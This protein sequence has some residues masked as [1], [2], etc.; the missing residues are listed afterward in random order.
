MPAVSTVNLAP[1]RIPLTF[2]SRSR[3]SAGSKGKEKEGE[4]EGEVWVELLPFPAPSSSTSSSGGE[5]GDVLLDSRSKDGR[6]WLLSPSAN[7]IALFHPPPSAGA[8]LVFSHAKLFPASLPPVRAESEDAEAATLR[9]AAKRA[10]RAVEKVLVVVRSRTALAHVL[11]PHPAPSLSSTLSSRARCTI[12]SDLPS[13][14]ASYSLSATLPSGVHVGVYVSPLRDLFTLSL[15][16]PSAPA[17]TSSV[18]AAADT[19]RWSTRLSSLGSPPSFASAP[20]LEAFLLSALPPSSSGTAMKHLL[21]HA[22][23]PPFS[24]LIARVREAHLAALAPPPLSLSPLRQTEQEQEREGAAEKRLISILCRA[25]SLPRP[26]PPSPVAQR[27]PSSRRRQD[28]EG[29]GEEEEGDEEGQEEGGARRCLPGLGWIIR[30]PQTQTLEGGGGAAGKGG[31]EGRGWEYEVLFLDGEHL[32][33][34]L[35]CEPGFRSPP[36]DM[37]ARKSFEGGRVEV[38][39]RHGVTHVLPP[40]SPTEGPPPLLPKK[41]QRRMNLVVEMLALFLPSAPS[42]VDKEEGEGLM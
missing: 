35:F 27:L 18:P 33:L 41:L 15:S 9:K 25:L 21:T 8:P 34:R 3:S 7:S 32:R 5:G 36:S 40:P 26:V 28:G 12:F 10:W 4:A 42:S 31:K 19:K 38:E 6:V 22:L 39:D 29:A 30:S 37:E 23:S 13:S 20:D 16:P 24:A 11:L 2:S 1:F 17:S 14:A